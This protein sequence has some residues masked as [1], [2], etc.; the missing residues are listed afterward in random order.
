MAVVLPQITEALTVLAFVSGLP[1]GSHSEYIWAPDASACL[2][3]TP[4]PKM[5]IALSRKQTSSMLFSAELRVGQCSWCAMLLM[6]EALSQHSIVKVKDP[7]ALYWGHSGFA[8]SGFFKLLMTV[9]HLVCGDRAHTTIPLSGTL[10]CLT[11]WK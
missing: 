8:V 7:K 9:S 1:V 2:P 6:N 3:A 5:I 11:S 10:N 4:A